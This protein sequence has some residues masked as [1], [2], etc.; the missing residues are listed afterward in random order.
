LN[1]LGDIGGG[2]MFLAFGIVA[3]LWERTRSGKGQVVEAAIIDGGTSMM[4]AL[5]AVVPAGRLSLDRGRN[6]LGG[7]APFYRCYVCADGKEIAVGP[8]EPH[9][10]HLLL[11]KIGAPESLSQEQNDE[12][13]WSARADLLADIFR[14]RTSQD[15]RAILEGTDACFA[16]VLSANE[17]PAHPQMLHRE[18]YVNNAGQLQA[19]PAPRFSRTPG[20]IRAAGSGADL[21]AAWKKN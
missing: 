1:L 3:A 10:Y 2:S 7:A 12:R 18:V 6:L 11:E 8:L 19:A 21:L 14:T 4:S 16:P 15:W 20:A 13:N 17:A 9:F 5:A